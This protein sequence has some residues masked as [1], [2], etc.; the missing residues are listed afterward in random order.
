VTM[1]FCE[2]CGA[3]LKVDMF[4]IEGS[5]PMSLEYRAFKFCWVC[6]D[7]YNMKHPTSEGYRAKLNKEVYGRE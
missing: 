7:I 3:N 6:G 2:D 5:T 4:E 1:D